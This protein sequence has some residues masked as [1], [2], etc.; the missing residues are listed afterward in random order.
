VRTRR[1]EDALR[2]AN[3]ALHGR[4]SDDGRVSDFFYVVAAV[5]AVGMLLSNC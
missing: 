2:R 5:V 4:Q 3:D 1:D